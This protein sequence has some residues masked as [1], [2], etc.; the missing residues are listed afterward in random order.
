M[1]HASRFH[2]ALDG[3]FSRALAHD[4]GEPDHSCA[5]LPSR[6]RL[7]DLQTM[8]TPRPRVLLLSM[9]ER[10]SARGRK[11]MSGWLG[12]ASVAAFPGKLDANG[13]PTSEVFVSE[14]APRD[15]S[16]RHGCGEP[17]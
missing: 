7:K 9:T 17:R 10:T 2:R 11:Y 15:G 16:E 3:A 1:T 12:K 5:L 8:H 6:H 14:P 4:G 13:H